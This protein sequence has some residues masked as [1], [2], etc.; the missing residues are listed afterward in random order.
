MKTRMMSVVAV[1]LMATVAITVTGC[2]GGSAEHTASSSNIDGRGPITYVQGKDNNGVVSQIIDVWN[3]SHPDERVTLKEQSDSADQQ[4]DDLVQNFQAQNAGYDVVSV[5]VIWTPE[6]AAKG[7]LQPLDGPLALSN[8]DALMAAPLQAAIY[9]GVQYAAPVTSDG[10]LLYYRSD[11]V[12]TPPS[13]W[14][15]LIAD[16]AI[17]EANNI[18]CYAGQ[19]AQ[20]EGL[21]VNVSEQING[22]G[23]TIVGA[24]GITPTLDTANARDGLQELVDAVRSGDIPQA[25]LTYKEEDGRTAFEDGK[26]LFYRNWPYQYSL[27][28]SGTSSQVV[29]KFG[30]APLVTASTLGGHNAAISVYSAHKATAHDFL[31]FLESEDIQKNYFVL[32]ASNAPVLTALYSDPDIVAAAPYMPALQQS[33]ERAVPR[34]ITPFYPAVTKAI[35]QDAFAALSG[36]MSVDEALAAMQTAIQA[37]AAQQ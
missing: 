22:A 3:A 29:G 32:K 24:D 21:T 35:Q 31:E 8:T 19:L 6:F 2:S 7:W 15:E 20:Y 37:A 16:C 30:V 4:H 26:L 25:A 17:A 11:L 36:T 13:S 18:G 14:A 10:G 1:G 28:S 34:P 27:S 23:G 12:A 5:D 33:I 9:H